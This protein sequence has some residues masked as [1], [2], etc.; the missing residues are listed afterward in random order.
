MAIF[1]KKPAEDNSFAKINR[2]KP[3]T[4]V[5]LSLFFTIMAICTVVPV[6]LVVSI[7][8]S[9]STSLAYN[10]FAFIPSGFD[11][12][13]YVGLFKTGSQ[14]VDCYKVTIVTTAVHT[15]LSVFTMAAFAFVLAQQRFSGKKFYSI[16]LLIPMLFSGGMVPSYIINVNYLHL[17]DTFWILVLPGLVNTFNVIVLR[18]F[19]QSTIP[20]EMFDAAA[21][22][23]AN[24]FRVFRTIVLPLSKAGLAT[25]ALFV[26]VGKWNEWFTGMLYIDNPKLVPVQ[27][28]LTRIQ[29]KLD[30]IKNNS[31][32]ASTP[33]GQRM[34][35]SMPT[36]QTRMAILVVSTL[37]IIFAYPFFQRFFIQ[38]LTVGSV[39]G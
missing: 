14:L 3:L 19:I 4:N 21:I 8:I 36:E 23:G 9:S 32:Y 24:E 39:K 38:G 5:L 17:Y 11:F 13:A 35:M 10:G 15:V 16:Y 6:L 7:S 1:K 26:M 37:P 12:T 27:T 22:D 31:D 29:Q 28:M 25:I 18:T 30:F 2:V 20:V 33:D 34:L